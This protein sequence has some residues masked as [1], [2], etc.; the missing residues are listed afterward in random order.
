MP[1]GFV[2]TMNEKDLAVRCMRDGV[3]GTVLSVPPGYWGAP[4]YGT[5]GDFASMKSGDNIYFFHDRQLYG[6]GEMV[7]VGGACAHQNFPGASQPHAYDYD[8]IQHD[9]LYD[10]GERSVQQRWICTFKPSP[11]FFKRGVDMDEALSAHPGAFRML[12]VMWKLSF[13]KLDYEENAALQDVV[14]RANRRTLQGSGAS[15]ATVKAGWSAVHTSLEMKLLPTHELDVAPMVASAAAGDALRSEKAIEAALLFY[16]TRGGPP[17]QRAFGQWDY[18]SHQV[19]ASP[20]K[21]PDW[22]DKIDV[23][24]A[25]FIPGHSPSLSRLLVIELKKGSANG[26]F[27]EQVMKYVD[28]VKEEYAHQD[29]SL[30]RATLVAHDFDESAL[31]QHR[32]AAVRRYTVGRRQPESK[33]WRDLTLVRYRYV[34]RSKRLAFKVEAAPW[35]S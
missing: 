18:L 7:E 26:A 14:L 12:R 34:A 9:I 16:L 32:D 2:M 10:T 22:M 3:Y 25:A 17:A 1:A 27:V 28:W 8:K 15:R 20:F 5:F 19:A 29:Y 21:P 33:E 6:I 4:G 13:I 11:F 24:G 30:V 35:K 31:G 23:F